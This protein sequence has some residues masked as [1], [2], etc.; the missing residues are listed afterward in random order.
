MQALA[1]SY[2]NSLLRFANISY[3]E[4]SNPTHNNS[5]RAHAKLISHSKLKVI[6]SNCRSIRSQE[7]RAN[8]EV[9]VYEYTPDIIIGCESHLD[10]TYEL[11]EV[12][13]SGYT[14][15]R[16]DHSLGGG[17]IFLCFRETLPVIKQP[18]FFND[19]EAVWAKLVFRSNLY[20]F[21]LSAT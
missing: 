13:P 8:L 20:L 19:A 10:S 3:S 16:K 14:V 12:F 9:L 4:T 17:G 5:Q 2:Q 7:K 1:A 6:S 15:L 21:F 11:S 18:L